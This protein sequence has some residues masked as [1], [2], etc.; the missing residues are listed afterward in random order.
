MEDGDGFVSKAEFIILSAA[1]IGGLNPAIVTAISARFR[2]LDKDGGGSLAYEE[3]L[4]EMTPQ[5]LHFISI[6][7]FYT[8]L[9]ILK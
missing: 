5:V 2:E 9:I 3:L 4:E 1:R 6:L 7:L 8:V